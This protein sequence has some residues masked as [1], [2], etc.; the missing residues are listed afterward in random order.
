MPEG[1]F[2]GG[3]LDGMT[4][5]LRNEGN[6]LAVDPDQGV[7]WLYKRLLDQPAGMPNYA[8]DMTP[9]ETD[10]AT[11]SRIYDEE[12]SIAAAEAGYDVIVIPGEMPTQ[13][14]IDEEEVLTDGE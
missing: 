12:R 4:Y 6:V 9:G 1:S 7:A 3:P 13:E 5:T 11:G 2:V 10:P 14:E 8:L